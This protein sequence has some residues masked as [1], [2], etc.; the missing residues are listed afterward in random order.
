MHGKYFVLD[1]SVLVHDPNC[2]D[3]FGSDNTVVLSMVVPQE[4]QEIR[5]NPR[6]S[7]DV[8]SAATEALNNLLRVR[9]GQ[10]TIEVDEVTGDR[11][12]LAQLPGGGKLRVEI[13]HQHA[14]EIPDYVDRNLPDNRIIA[15][16]LNLR[17]MLEVTGDHDPQVTLVTKDG[18]M[19]LTADILGLHAEDYR[20]D[21]RHARFRGI[22]QLPVP[23]EIMRQFW[24]TGRVPLP[25]G[26]LLADL[27]ARY[28]ATWDGT[29]N[30][31]HLPDVENALGVLLDRVPVEA[32]PQMEIPPVTTTEGRERLL[33][34]VLLPQH[35]AYTWMPGT[36]VLLVSEHNLKNA[37]IAVVETDDGGRLV[38]EELPYHPARQ[39]K[40]FEGTPVEGFTPRDLAQI[41]AM[42]AALN[43]RRLFV[44]IMGPTG[45]GKTRL[46][47][48][49]AWHRLRRG[50]I[51]SITITRPNAL[52]GDHDLGFTT[53][54]LT[55]KMRP[56]I[57]PFLEF[58][59]R[60]MRQE[61]Y[62]PSTQE[63][64]IKYNQERLY[65]SRA[66]EEARTADLLEKWIRSD[67]IR[68]VPLSHVQGLDLEDSHLICLE[69]QTL[70]PHE[71]GIL[72][73]RAARGTKVVFEG[74]PRQMNRTYLSP[75]SSGLVYASEEMKD[76]PHTATVTL[77]H[78]YRSPVAEAASR[79]LIR[80]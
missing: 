35:R 43:P 69:A 31:N 9:N 2:L 36:Y 12:W 79:K 70:T 1:T 48:H 4:L 51:T 14:S 75:E 68:V 38:L 3:K 61:R 15:L 62:Q 26:L 32:H 58:M 29:A 34:Q 10:R 23:E 44:T 47:T 54:D 65:G 7:L 25:D 49:A 53:G 11:Y 27:F 55:E 16:A 30:E 28:G 57:M 73:A 41:C 52:L 77:N 17:R 56:L 76:E 37:A 40:G 24:Q 45:T 66:S 21:R 33:Q 13:N 18:A 60:I 22:V 20:Y 63:E 8:R 42:D 50:E 67:I 80:K 72:A 39:R 5:R 59:K 74:D 6:K 46:C 71:S 64:R 19:L 78:I